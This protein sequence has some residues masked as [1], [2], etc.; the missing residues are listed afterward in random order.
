MYMG[1]CAC[2]YTMSKG[3]SG[4]NDSLWLENVQLFQTS[5]GVL[6]RSNELQKVVGMKNIFA[7][8]L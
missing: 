1:A 7:L 4:I 3:E 6:E 5:M 8:A 2:A